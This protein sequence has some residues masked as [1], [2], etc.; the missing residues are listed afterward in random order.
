MNNL[1]AKY[2]IEEIGNSFSFRPYYHYKKKLFWYVFAII[3]FGGLSVYFSERG[4]EA[5]LIVCITLFGVSTWFF[6][7]ELLY[8][9]PIRYT[10]DTSDNAVYQSNLLF[11]KREIMK[12]D[13]VIIFQSSEMGSW[14]YKM[15]KKKNQFVKNYQISENFG[16]SKKS[17][18]SLTAYEREILDKIEQMLTQD[19]SRIPANSGG[20]TIFR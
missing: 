6:L 10:F 5:F 9:I 20:T 17:D 1:K 4:S 11:S 7:K 19:S 14:H 12:L 2:Q 15:G 16:S 13:E 8:Y 3:L 18:E